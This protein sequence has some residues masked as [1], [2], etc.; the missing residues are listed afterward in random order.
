LSFPGARESVSSISGL[1]KPSDAVLHSLIL[2]NPPGHVMVATYHPTTP[3]HPQL[4]LRRLQD[5]IKCPRSCCLCLPLLPTENILASF[6]H[7]G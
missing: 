6:W 1:T 4:P 5:R 3:W 2:V 7:Y